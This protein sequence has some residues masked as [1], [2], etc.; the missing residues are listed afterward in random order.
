[1]CTAITFHAKNHYFGRNL[2]FEHNFGE[3]VTI[4]PR[5]FAF[6][7]HAGKAVST[8]PA[9]IGIAAV[10]KEYPLYFDATNEDGLSMAGLYF[11][12]NAVYLPH[13]DGMHNIAPHE[14]IP[15]VLCQCKTVKEASNLLAKTNLVDIPYRNAYPQSPLH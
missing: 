7:F 2:D 9:M 8:H 6:T 12:G 1:M 10:D 15:W 14:F 3:T 13:R 5:N 4:T 11:P